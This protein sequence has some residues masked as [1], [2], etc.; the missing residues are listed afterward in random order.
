MANTERQ[1]VGLVGLGNMGR[2]VA[3]NIIKKGFPL[4]VFERSERVREWAAG[5]PGVVLTRSLR[6]L[7][8]ASDVVLLVVP[9]APQ[10]QEVLFKDQ[11][12]VAGMRRGAIVVDM[13]TSD[14]IRSQETCRR[15]DARGISY[16]DAPMSGGSVGAREGTMILM[17]GGAGEVLERCRGVFSAIARKVVHAGGPGAGQHVKLLQ[18][19]L[20]FTLYLATCEALW[21]GRSLGFDPALLIDVFQHS[22]ARSYETELRFPRFILPGTFESGAILRLALKDARLARQVR[23]RAGVDLPLADKVLLYWERAVQQL[24]GEA[25][26]TRVF[27]LVRTEADLTELAKKV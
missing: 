27:E 23:S 21:M 13:T 19:Q 12:I 20:S 6:E 16:L 17:V 26:F 2:G 4:T 9:D 5:W 25:D 22:N 10:V 15:L 24:G 18:N 14:P 1:R 11:G 7:G 8:V 3:E